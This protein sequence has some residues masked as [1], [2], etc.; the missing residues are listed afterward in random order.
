MVGV[1]RLFGFIVRSLIEGFFVYGS[2]IVAVIQLHR[3]IVEGPP[4]QAGDSFAITVGG[5][6]S[7]LIF[8]FVLPDA[9]AVDYV[10]MHAFD[11]PVQQHISF[12][13]GNIVQHLHG[14]LRFLAVDGN[15]HAIVI[16]FAV[17]V[18][19]ILNGLVQYDGETGIAALGHTGSAQGRFGLAHQVGVVDGCKHT[20]AGH[21]AVEFIVLGD[22]GV[23]AQQALVIQGVEVFEISLEVVGGIKVGH[24]EGLLVNVSI[25]VVRKA[26]DPQGRVIHGLVIA[27]AVGPDTPRNE[28]SAVQI[29][30]HGQII[31]QSLM[32]VIQ[33]LDFRPA[34]L[35]QHIILHQ[36]AGA[37]IR[38]FFGTILGRT[39]PIDLAVSRIAQLVQGRAPGIQNILTIAFQQIIQRNQRARL[40]HALVNPE[41]DIGI[42]AAGDHGSDFLLFAHAGNNFDFQIHIEAV[43]QILNGSSV[44]DEFLIQFFGEVEDGQRGTAG[45]GNSAQGCQAQDHHKRKQKGNQLFGLHTGTSFYF[46]LAASGGVDNE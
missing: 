15:A 34:K 22:E 23:F 21:L 40:D 20:A 37:G 6:R 7:V 9:L 45:L 2:S 39:N 30:N 46:I 33:R 11:T 35:F 42:I 29:G 10:V 31:L 14:Q 17:N 25:G 36:Q 26:V 24:V 18:A 1:Q 19:A 27:P 8:D 28:G 3:A 13:A 38:Q 44:V 41:H 43:F 16:A 12:V 5:I 32:H 4:V